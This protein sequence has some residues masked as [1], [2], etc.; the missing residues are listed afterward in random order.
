MRIAVI[1][2][3]HDRFPASLPKKICDAEEI[4][5]LGDVCEPAIVYE[6][7][8]LGP[9]LH[10]V[11]G[12]CDSHPWPLTLNLEFWNYA[13]AKRIA[14]ESATQALAN[15]N[16]LLGMNMPGDPRVIRDPATGA[17]QQLQVTQRNIPGSIVTNGIDATIMLSLSGANFGGS[18][19]DW[20]V[21]TLGTQGTLT[22]NYDFPKELAAPRTIPNVSPMRSLP[23]LH[24]GASSCQAVGSRNYNNLAP[25]LPRFRFNLPVYWTYGPH[26]ISAIAHWLSGL[27][28]DNDVDANGQLGRLAP[29]VTLD[30]QYGVTIPKWVGE[31]LALRVGFFNL[32]DTYPPVTRDQNGHETLL[33]DPRGRMVYANL[34]AIF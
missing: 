13:Y 26:T 2:D 28:N 32:F 23:P 25:P 21:I 27:E 22:L 14:L 1:S 15:D 9:P 7:A 33:Y 3:T 18:R 6:L 34:K 4:W 8:A 12:N 31:E 10:V 30:L 29:Q 5:H 20:G 24:C 16:A 11:A 17:V 19:G